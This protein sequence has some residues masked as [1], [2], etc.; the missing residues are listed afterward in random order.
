MSFDCISNTRLDSLFKVLDRTIENKPLY[1]EVKEKRI[2]SLKLKLNNP[3]MPADEK[4]SVAKNLC[5]EYNVYRT[6]S[7]LFYSTLMELY[8]QQAGDREGYTDS[9]LFRSRIFRTMGLLKESSEVLDKIDTLNLPHELKTTYLYTKLSVYNA[10]RDFSKNN[11]DKEI[12][13]NMAKS[14][15]IILLKDE[16]L[17]PINHIYV[18]A[19]QLIIDKQYDEALSELLEVYGSMNPEKREAGILAYSIAIIYKAKRNFDMEL[20]YFARSAIADLK[21]G[22][23]EYVSLRRLASLLFEYG[24]IDRA[25]NYMKCSMEDAIFCNARL[26]TLEASEMFLIIDKSYQKK[27]KQQHRMVVIFLVITLGLSISIF[28]ALIH[29]RKQNKRLSA[30]KDQLSA[31]NNSL[32]ETNKILSDANTI[33]VEYIGLY[34][35]HFSNY[36][37][38]INS[39]KMKAQKI[40]KTSGIEAMVSFMESSLNSKEDLKEFYHNFDSTVLKLFPDFIAKFNSLL[41]EGEKIVPKPGEGLTPELRIFALIRLGIT[42]SIKIAHFLRYSVSTIYNYRTKMRNKATG[43][44]DDFENKVMMIDIDKQS[45]DSDILKKDIL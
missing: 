7:A 42:D 23:K 45:I 43:D 21:N 27:E 24:D 11:E 40:A 30:A 17:L 18:K 2:D 38:K 28:M 12:Y 41:I 25:Y 31:S 32:R 16:N 44:R 19:E 26:R 8:A 4:I 39:Y 15:R 33:K 10:L 1:S 35:E 9:E 34:I 14:L 37:S 20:E 13:E 29:I 36:L 3:L 22:I 5:M 6:D